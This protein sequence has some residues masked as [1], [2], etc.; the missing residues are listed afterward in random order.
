MI[1]TGFTWNPET[2]QWVMNT[3]NNGIKVRPSKMYKFLNA[4][5]RQQLCAA[6]GVNQVL[7][8]AQYLTPVVADEALPQ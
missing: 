2:K 8:D 6:L 4:A 5:A 3:E 1:A 7:W